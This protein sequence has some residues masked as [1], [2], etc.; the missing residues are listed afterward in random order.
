MVDPG[1]LFRR[2]FAAVGH[3]IIADL[4]VHRSFTLFNMGGIACGHLTTLDALRNALLLVALPLPDLAFGV[5]ILRGSVV[6]VFINLVRELVL[7][8]MQRGAVGG[9]QMAVVQ[10]AHVMLLL[11]KFGFF[12]LQMPC[13]SG[14]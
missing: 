2:Q 3:A 6:L 13:L 14:S 12:F 11:V 8:L 4:M 9:G 1:L 5:Y 10:L 7:L